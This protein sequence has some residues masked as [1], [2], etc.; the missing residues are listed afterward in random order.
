MNIQLTFS[1]TLLFVTIPI[2]TTLLVYYVVKKIT[3]Q[4][5]KAIHISVQATAIFY[6]VAVTIL[7][8]RLLQV[9][10]VG[11]IL[12]SL[13]LLLAIILIIQWKQETEVVLTK[14]LKVLTRF[15]FLVFG[16]LY[17]GL[18]IYEIIVFIYDHYVS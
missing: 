9:Q 2:F 12:I 10:L 11:I 6:I 1:M 18:I 14:G 8:Q 3:K 4:K 13:I 15:S 7:L 16:F 5:W 17:V